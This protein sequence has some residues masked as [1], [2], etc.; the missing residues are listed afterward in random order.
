M[1]IARTSSMRK[2]SLCGLAPCRRHAHLK[3][4][5]PSQNLVQRS[6]LVCSSSMRTLTLHEQIKWCSRIRIMF[7][8]VVCDCILSRFVKCWQ[9]ETHI[10]TRLAYALRLSHAAHFRCATSVSSVYVRHN[11]VLRTLTIR[12]MAGQG[13]TSIFRSRPSS[14]RCS[15]RRS[16]AGCRC[17][18]LKTSCTSP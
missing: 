17:V 7:D 11:F 5:F 9:N 8:R 12:C 6:P 2:K 15:R 3:C 10:Q 1:C 13:S 14:G 18:S 4:I 16:R